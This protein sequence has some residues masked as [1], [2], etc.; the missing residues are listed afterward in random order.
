MS[1]YLQLTGEEKK[2]IVKSQLKSIQYTRYGLE[3]HL[4]QENSL[5]EP[6]DSMIESYTKQLLEYDLKQSVLESCLDELNIE[7]PENEE[8]NN[9]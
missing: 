7:Y 8:N 6:S 9:V 1:E 5:P 4:L 2:Q 3:L